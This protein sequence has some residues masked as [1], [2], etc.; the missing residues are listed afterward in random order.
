MIKKYKSDIIFFGSIIIFGV[1][2]YFLAV[3]VLPFFLGLVMAFAINPIIKKIQRLIP[4]RDLAVTDSQE[5]DTDEGLNWF[6]VIITSIGYFV[7]IIYSFDY[8][9][10]K[11]HKYFSDKRSEKIGRVIDNFKKTFLSYFKQR[12]KVVLIYTVIFI[13]S[14]FIIGVPGALIF[15]LIA[16]FLCYI[17][18]LQYV[19]L[20][21]LSMGCL[22]LSIE[23]NNSFFMYFGIVLGVFILSSVLEEVVLFPKIMKNASVMNPA[24]MMVAIA[25]WSYLLGMLGVLIAIPLTSLIL[26]YIDQILLYRNKVISNE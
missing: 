15:G 18:Y 6:F 23:N 1:L 21:P 16:G 19:V 20:I 24:V 9:E 10:K 17:P 22:I 12:S 5:K 25:L 8:F 2:F 3:V 7:Y 13:T 26:S 11:L 4:N 14:F